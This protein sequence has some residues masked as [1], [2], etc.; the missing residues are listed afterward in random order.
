MLDKQNPVVESEIEN[1]IA[2]APA[3]H[4]FT[5]LALKKLEMQIRKKL[6]ITPSRGAMRNSSMQKTG[7]NI[8]GNKDIDSRMNQRD[9]PVGVK[10]L[11]P[12]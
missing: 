3:S 2:S 7:M 11:S 9:T 5:E 12:V 1:F 8:M 6:G 10:P 4:Q